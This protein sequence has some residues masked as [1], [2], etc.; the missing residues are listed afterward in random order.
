MNTSSCQIAHAQTDASS[1][2][3]LSKST[4]QLGLKE[5]EKRLTIPFFT[6]GN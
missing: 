5:I 2:K 1:C 3:T 6:E 4:I